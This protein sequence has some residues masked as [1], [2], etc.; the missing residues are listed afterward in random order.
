M[1][2]E[3]DLHLPIKGNSRSEATRLRIGLCVGVVDVL[4]RRSVVEVHQR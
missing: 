1:L 2:R 4:R 3:S